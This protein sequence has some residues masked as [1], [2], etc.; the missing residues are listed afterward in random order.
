MILAPQEMFQITVGHSL[1][2]EN[3]KTTGK[4]WCETSLLASL[5]EIPVK[6]PTQDTEAQKGGCLPRVQ[7]K[8]TLRGGD[9]RALRSQGQLSFRV[10]FETLKPGDFL[11]TTLFRVTPVEMSQAM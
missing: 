9:R 8:R 5:T 3:K 4:K 2:E 1:R 10:C 7:D 11:S 6:S